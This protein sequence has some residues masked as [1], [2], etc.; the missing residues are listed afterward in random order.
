MH[1][2][3]HMEHIFINSSRTACYLPIIF[4]PKRKQFAITS[5]LIAHIYGAIYNIEFIIK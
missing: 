1:L 2:L 5:T 3:I 4:Y